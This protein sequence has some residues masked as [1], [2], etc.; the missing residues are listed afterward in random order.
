MSPVSRTVRLSLRFRF[1]IAAIFV[2]SVM[3]AFF[4]GANITAVYPFVEAVF[5]G[6][7]MHEWIDHQI[8]EIGRNIDDLEKRA[9]RL[10]QGLHSALPEERASLELQIGYCQGRLAAERH[11]LAAV[12][13]I[14]PYIRRYLPSNT[15]RTLIF[16]VAFV[17]LSTLLKGIFLTTQNLLVTRLANQTAM[18]L[19]KQCYQRT[20]A[21]DLAGFEEL[22]TGDLMS[23]FTGDIHAVSVGIRSLFGVSLLEPL[24]MLRKRLE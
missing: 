16:I 21:M 1:T 7:S 22:R 19:R 23:R 24:K 14:E 6:E 11:A 2:C 20:L 8:H 18:R 12:H 15:F 17:I 9:T 10:V 4:W 3:V 5:R 13:W